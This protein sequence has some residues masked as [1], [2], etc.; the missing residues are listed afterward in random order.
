MASGESGVFRAEPVPGRGRFAV[1]A[2]LRSLVTSTLLVG[3]YFLAPTRTPTAVS[4]LLTLV[5]GLL[6]ISA[7]LVWQVMGILNSPYPAARAVGALIVTVPMFLVLFASTY[8]L[9]ATANPDSWSEPINRM[10]ALYY[11]VTVF[12]TV[13]FGDITA[14]SEG[15]RIATTLQ[16]L[17]GLILVGLIARVVVGAVHVSLERRP[18]E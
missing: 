5:G 12:A 4:G 15:A 6:L 8:Y 17:T 11:T 18:R 16:M 14:V 3:A 13:G 10:D 7:A 9:I 1:H 2:L